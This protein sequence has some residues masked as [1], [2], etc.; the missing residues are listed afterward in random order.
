MA[1]KLKVQM[2][3]L[4]YYKTQSEIDGQ[5][6]HV[7]LI[8]ENPLPLDVEGVLSPVEPCMRSSI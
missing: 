6:S 2:K 1:I 7:S 4:V 5:S 8:L 3:Y